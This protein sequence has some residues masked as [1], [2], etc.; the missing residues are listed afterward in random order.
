MR[1]GAESQGWAVVTGALSG[2]GRAFAK[3]VARREYRVLA[4][5]RRRDRLDALACEV[6]AQPGRSRP[7]LG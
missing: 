7:W 2:M 4:I 1:T 5:A 3:E 6:G